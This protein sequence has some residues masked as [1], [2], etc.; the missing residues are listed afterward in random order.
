MN[1]PAPIGERILAYCPV[2]VA[3]VVVVIEISKPLGL[4]ISTDNQL[5]VMI[6]LLAFLSVLV[7]LLQ[8][9]QKQ[10]LEHIQ[11]L[12][13]RSSFGQFLDGKK[14]IY[15]AA[16]R[17]CRSTNKHIRTVVTTAGPKAP[18][19]FAEAVARTLQER[20]QAGSEVVFDAV[21]VLNPDQITDMN[22]FQRANAERFKVYE[23]YDVKDCVHLYVIEA[24][25]PINF[26]ALVV[27]SKHV[28]LGFSTFKGAE[29]LD[30]GLL[31]ENR[32]QLAEDMARWFEKNILPNAER[33]DDW[34]ARHLRI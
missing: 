34:V 33:Y 9:E 16:I 7:G 3:V 12:L 20:R 26:D 28:I 25:L 10:R 15:D 6:G 22:L 11:S 13:E 17:L 1:S 32:P 2:V 21:I 5:S 27:D 23:K 31:F 30:T 19:E 14:L 29:K 4:Q 8:G 18:D 24:K